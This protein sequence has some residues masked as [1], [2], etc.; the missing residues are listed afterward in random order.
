[1]GSSKPSFKEVQ[2]RTPLELVPVVPLEDKLLMSL[3]SEESTKQFILCARDLESLASE[4]TKPWLRSSPTRSL[5][6]PRESVK[7][8]TPS[9]RRTKLRELPRVTDELNLQLV[10]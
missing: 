2:E 6:L 9:R 7:T 8:H 1:M 3:H 5:T 4:L 10:C